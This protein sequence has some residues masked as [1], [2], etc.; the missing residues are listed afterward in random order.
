MVDSVAFRS[1]AFRFYTWRVEK[2]KETPK[3]KVLFFGTDEFSASHLKALIQEKKQPDSCIASID[4]VCPPDQM[5]GR[6]RN[7]LTP[8][9]TKGLAE[10]YNIPVHHTPPRAET[11]D[12]WEVPGKFDLGV[13]VS[14]G[15]FIPPKVI[16]SFEK[17][18]INVHP[19]LLPKFRGAAPIQHTILR[20][21]GETGVT[22]QELDDKEFDAGRILAQQKVDLSED[23]AP[24]FKDLRD[25]L[26][27]VGQHILVD[28]L[29]N[30]DECKRLAKP[31]DPNAITKAPKIKKEWA[32][33]D[34]ENMESWQIEQ[35]H[36]AIGEQYPLRTTFTFSRIKRSKKVLQKYIQ[37][38]MFNIFIPEDS[39]IYHEQTPPEPGQ[40]IFED[41][42]KTLHVACA[43]GNAIAFTH[44]KADSK[45]TISV[46][47]FV[48]GYEIHGGYGQFGVF[49]EDYVKPGKSGVRVTKRRHEYAKSI[50]KRLGMRRFEYDYH[51]HG[52]TSGRR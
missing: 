46:K 47:D 5:T 7:I 12:N 3:Y 17:G 27:I 25:R 4:L 31:Q 21:E 6:K 18:A 41:A 13:V 10:L 2:P 34:F 26:S 23:N 51:Y 40:F 48:N 32:E 30:F 29:R 8:A 50:R 33:I 37:M 52:K 43:D 1:V 22:I 28:T 45:D 19:S 16:E 38:Q 9:A 14:F 11:L 49:D 20:G 15:Y 35:L 39:P 24:R 44:I 36:R 42:T